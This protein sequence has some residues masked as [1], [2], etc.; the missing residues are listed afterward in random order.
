MYADLFVYIIDMSAGIGCKHTSIVQAILGLF[1]VLCMVNNVALPMFEASD[2]AAHFA[3]ADF[4]ARERR[5]PNLRQEVPSHEAFQPPLYYMALAPIIGL[6]DRSNLAEISQL[7][8]D[9]FDR[10]LNADY[11]SVQ[12]LHLHGLAEQF[13]YRG[14]VWAVR[15]ARLFSSFLGAATVWLVFL[16][17]QLALRGQ[18]HAV[19]ASYLAAALTAFNPKFIHISSIVSNDIAVTFAATLACWWMLRMGGKWQVW[20]WFVLGGLIGV[21]GLCKIQAFGLVIP[22]AVLWLFTL[23]QSSILNPQSLIPHLKHLFALLIGFTLLSAWWFGLNW[24]RY[25]DPLAWNE[26]QTANAALLRPVPLGLGEM[27][28]RVPQLFIS[29]WGV[30]GIEKYFPVGIDRLLFVG[31]G[32]AVLGCIWHIS[33]AGVDWARAC[34][35]LILATWQ[36]TTLVLFLSWMRT[37]IGTENSRLLMPSVALPA[38]WVAVGWLAL[39]PDRWRPIAAWLAGSGMLVL[40]ISAP[41]L[42]IRPAFATPVT[43]GPQQV[44]AFG[45]GAKVTFG[46]QVQLLHS[47]FGQWRVQAGQPLKLR[48]F[49]GAT[50]PI[51]K[52]Y[53]ILLEAVDLQGELIARRRFIPFQGRFATNRWQPNAYFQDDYDLPIDATAMRGPATIQLALLTDDVPPRLLEIQPNVFKFELGQ[54]K[55]A[56]D[57]TAVPPPPSPS[58]TANANFGG[59]IGLRGYDLALEGSQASLCLYF[60]GLGSASTLTTPSIDKNYTLFVH[61]LDHDGKLLA[62]NDAQ[63]WMGKFPTRLWEPNELVIEPRVVALP[64]QAAKILIGW[65]DAAN[66]QRLLANNSDGV[67]WPADAVLIWER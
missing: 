32:L 21:A 7:N 44:A 15:A 51:P 49:W 14:A 56:N 64:P 10:E 28:G 33:R 18:T 16:I 5:L 36:I 40:A 24:V 38:I 53:R 25:G 60:A 29:F 3:Y 42:V 22:T 19:T 27:I 31:L 8:P 30:L 62:Q 61:V 45:G 67:R 1:M 37:H 26:V 46:G 17:A 50:Q 20:E 2:E 12:Q 9:W 52:S 23:R 47:E 65:Y 59:L 6:F 63:P 55:I 13:P 66:G 34:P 39:L 35:I 54:V 43:L 41:W 4:W 57:M 58:V 11:V 48:L